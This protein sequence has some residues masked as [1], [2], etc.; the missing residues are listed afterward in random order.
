[1]GII[2]IIPLFWWM[3]EMIYDH[4]IYV[5]HYAA[6]PLGGSFYPIIIIKTWFLGK[7]VLH[8]SGL[9]PVYMW[10]HVGACGSMW[11]HIYVTDSPYENRLILTRRQNSFFMDTKSL[12]IFLLHRK[13]MKD[14]KRLYF[15]IFYWSENELN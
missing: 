2:W 14:L 12:L 7:N 8:R 3:N 13:I 1:M 6:T 4:K 9:I 15:F 5:Q 10:E 11:E